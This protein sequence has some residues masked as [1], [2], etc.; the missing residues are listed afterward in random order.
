MPRK[1]ATFSH[2]DIIRIYEKH[3][4]PGERA[5]VNLYFRFEA[6]DDILDATDVGLSTVKE[7]VDTLDNIVLFAQIFFT[8]ILKVKNKTLRWVINRLLKNLSQ[9][10][11]AADIA[12]RVQRLVLVG[13]QGLFRRVDAVVVRELLECKNLETSKRNRINEYADIQKLL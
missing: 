4:E 6:I 5:K 7:L 2:C 1:D 8:R 11:I 12:N 9:F 3:L 13:L 10:T